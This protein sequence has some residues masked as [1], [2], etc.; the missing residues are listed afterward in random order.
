MSGNLAEEA[1]TG[2]LVVGGQFTQRVNEI[3]ERHGITNSQYNV[4]RILAGCPEGHAR[5]DIAKRLTDR[6]PDVTR[7]VDR[8]ERSGYVERSWSAEN[9]RHSI[10]RITPA[11]AT[12]LDAMKP[13]MC[14]IH[15]EV[16]AAL[17]PA[18]LEALVRISSQLAAD[19]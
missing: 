3:C 10:A 11:G 18:D 17:S 5:C 19:A 12:L 8:L 14:A 1:L 6:A 13:D 4:L 2:L 16:A 7:L 9:R 15:K